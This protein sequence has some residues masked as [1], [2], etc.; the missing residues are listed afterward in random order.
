VND[1]EVCSDK[2]ANQTAKEKRNKKFTFHNPEL[3][4]GKNC[5]SEKS[6][7][8]KLYEKLNFQN[9]YSIETSTSKTSDYIPGNSK[10][11]GKQNAIE[12]VENNYVANKC[13][14]IILELFAGKKT[15]EIAENMGVLD[16]TIFILNSKFSM[17]RK[18]FK[19]GD[20]QNHI[21]NQSLTRAVNGWLFNQHL[22][23]VKL[24]VSDLTNA[25]SKTL[26]QPRVT[27]STII[28]LFRELNQSKTSDCA[29]KVKAK[30]RK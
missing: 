15:K 25:V 17:F 10:E 27:G 23:S 11:K 3:N 22:W 24:V 20:P 9:N 5:Q 26:P 6:M 7:T 4:E 8:G 13:V 30:G 12:E 14:K 28:N 2:S 21:F 19:T 16:E 18:G 29:S 1:K